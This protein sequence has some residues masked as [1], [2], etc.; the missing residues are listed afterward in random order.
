MIVNPE[1]LVETKK[2]AFSVESVEVTPSASTQT[3][4]PSGTDVLFNKLTVKG[5]SNLTANN[6][7][8]GVSIFGVTGTYSNQTTYSVKY[9]MPPYIRR[10]G[11]SEDYVKDKSGY[12]ETSTT[13]CVSV[14]KN[15]TENVGT[16]VKD[17]SGNIISSDFP[18]EIGHGSG[19]LSC[20]CYV[21]S[22]S[23]AT[24]GQFTFVINKGQGVEIG[25]QFRVSVKPYVCTGNTVGAPSGSGN[26]V[27]A[28]TLKTTTFTMTAE[29][30][31]ASSYE[32]AIKSPTLSWTWNV[33]KFWFNSG[34]DSVF[35]LY[36][37]PESIT[38]LG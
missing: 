20:S 18:C 27:Q 16:L 32:M 13:S 28:G 33:D 31:S 19:T 24:S 5:D 25:D 35:W 9:Y 26:L 12:T 22:S 14:W 38:Y 2:K 30:S 8:K 7:K 10:G 21:P 11:T 29:Q 17:S 4:K 3:L 36:L 23:F 6:I 1:G 37:W 34:Y 15:D